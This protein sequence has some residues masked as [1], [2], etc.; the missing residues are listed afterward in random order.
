MKATELTDQ[1]FTEWIDL[2]LPSSHPFC[3]SLW[4]SELSV[5]QTYFLLYFTYFLFLF[6]YIER[7]LGEKSV[8]SPFHLLFSYLTIFDNTYFIQK[9]SSSNNRRYESY[10]QFPSLCDINVWNCNIYFLDVL[11]EKLEACVL[12]PALC[13]TKVNLFIKWTHC[14]WYFTFSEAIKRHN[15]I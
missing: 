15:D 9:Q 10:M 8:S 1:V 5:V 3:L 13:R 7:K 4:L 11:K 6:L 12:V 2:N 14:P